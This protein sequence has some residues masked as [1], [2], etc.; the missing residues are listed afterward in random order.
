M[1]QAYVESARRR[2]LRAEK[3]ERISLH[4]SKLFR[5]LEQTYAYLER[6]DAHGL[7]GKDL[8]DVFFVGPAADSPAKAFITHWGVAKNMDSMCAVIMNSGRIVCVIQV[9]ELKTH[10]WVDKDTPTPYCCSRES[11]DIQP[12]CNG[13][14]VSLTSD[15]MRDVVHYILANTTE[16]R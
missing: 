12:H 10:A 14:V 15:D 16:V 7:D 13:Y 4:T 3:E 1:E 9:G 2:E 8:P 5:E 11:K 6:N